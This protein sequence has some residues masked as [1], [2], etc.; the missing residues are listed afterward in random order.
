MNVKLFLK[1]ISILLLFFSCAEEPTKEPK[2]TIISGLDFSFQQEKDILYFGVVVIPKY[3]L[4]ELDSVS[5]DWYG[6]NKSNSP[7]NFKLFDNG[8]NGD[9]LEGDGLYSRKIPNIIDSLVYP[10]G[11]TTEIDS[12]NTN[13]SI[14]VYMNFIAN[15]GSDSTSIL[16]SFIIGNIIPEIIEIYAPD[17][18]IRPEGATVSFELISAKVFDAENNINWVGFT[19]YSIDDSSMMNNGN[20][21]Y[22]YDDGSSIVLYEPDFTSG[23]ELI[24]DG[25]YSFRIPIYGNAM[26]DTTLQTK[27]GEFKWEFITQDE[28]GEYSKIREHHVFIQ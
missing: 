11:E 8:S 23:D 14:I 17:T 6:S 27:T 9:I 4:Q 5:V 24:N 18:I 7:F 26:S 1:F 25:I 19:S 15:H 3:N 2:I 21:I 22:L 12:G 16:D 20:Y 28:A 13:T 10:I